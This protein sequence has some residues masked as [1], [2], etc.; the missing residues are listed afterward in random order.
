MVVL[1]LFS[2]GVLA[3]VGAIPGGGVFNSVPAAF[4]AVGAAVLILAAALVYLF[5][6]LRDTI[7]EGVQDRLAELQAERDG[8]Q[9]L[10]LAS[11][12]VSPGTNG[13][14]AQ[15]ARAERRIAALERVQGKP[16]TQIAVVAAAPRRSSVF[17]D[18]CPVLDVEGIGPVFA[19][20]LNRMGIHDTR[21]LWEANAAQVANQIDVPVSMVHKW[22]QMSELIAV[23]GIGPQYA[24]LLQRSGV[25]SI[26]ELKASKPEALLA[27][28]TR[29]QDALDIRIQGNAIGH[30]GVTHWVQAARNH[31]G[32]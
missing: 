10:R 7:D 12:E 9:D 30:A 23:K 31:R 13:W 4:F 11:L 18:V 29:T 6:T 28:V 32:G 17:G 21:Q 14:G 2:V 24:E 22:Q 5:L 8:T 20:A 26:A 19:K 3:Y 16:A 15:L 27:S 1:G 25:G